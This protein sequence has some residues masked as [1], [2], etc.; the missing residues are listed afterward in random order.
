MVSV[1]EE[2]ELH[3]AVTALEG[4][5]EEGIDEHE[6]SE[7][8]AERA[9][10]GTGAVVGDETVLVVVVEVRVLEMFAEEVLEAMEPGTVGEGGTGPAEV[11]GSAT[12]FGTDRGGVVCWYD[13]GRTRRDMMQFL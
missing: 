6:T 9:G 13:S 2:E 8:G 12:E 3:E 1:E 4:E 11:T 7:R 5:A 10:E